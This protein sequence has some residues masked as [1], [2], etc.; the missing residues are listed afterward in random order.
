MYAVVFV[1]AALARRDETG[2]G[3]SIDIGDLLRLG[4]SHPVG[5]YVR[6]PI[7]QILRDALV[8]G[9]PSQCPL[10]SLGDSGE[11]GSGLGDPADLAAEQ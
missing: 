8:A 5:P 4:V 2:K 11:N 6:H 10:H 9:C 3:A 1:L 7:Q